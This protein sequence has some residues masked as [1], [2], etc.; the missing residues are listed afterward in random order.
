MRIQKKNLVTINLDESIDSK[1]FSVD[2]IINKDAFLKAIKLI[3]DNVRFLNSRQSVQIE[4][5]ARNSNTISILGGRG[6]GKSS[7]IY[8]LKNDCEEN[9]K[10]DVLCLDIIDPTLVEAKG[11]FL[12]YVLSLLDAYVEKFINSPSSYSNDQI[13]KLERHSWREA[14][15][16]LAKGLCSVDG[17]D[18]QQIAEWGDDNY[19]FRMGM[20][21]VSSSREIQNNLYRLVNKAL[22][23]K[24]QTLLVL[25]FDDIDVDLS[26]SW[27]VLE[28][29]RK[30][31][32]LP[33]ILTIISGDEYLL[34]LSVRKAQWQKFD[35]DFLVSE[36]IEK[37]E[38]VEIRQSLEDQYLQ[39]ILKLENRISL[40][41]L[42]ELTSRLSYTLNFTMNNCEKN[43]ELISIYKDFF[44]ILGIFQEVDMEDCFNVLLSLP[45]RSQIHLIR[46]LLS[47][48]D[49]KASSMAELE[50]KVRNTFY[51][52][53]LHNGV[54]IDEI[55]KNQ[56]FI[57]SHILKYLTHSSN[58]RLFNC[59][60]LQPIALSGSQNEILFSLGSIFSLFCRRRPT[61][62]LDY[63]LRIAFTRN[64]IQKSQ[65]PLS[66]FMYEDRNMRDLIGYLIAERKPGMIAINFENLNQPIHQS[67][68]LDSK[69]NIVLE[70]EIFRIF[71]Y[72]PVCLVRKSGNRRIEKY[73]S[74][75]FLLGTIYDFMRTDNVVQ[76]IQKTIQL[77]IYSDL[78][79]SSDTRE[80][81]SYLAE[82]DLTITLNEDSY[83]EEIVKKFAQIFND[84][85]EQVIKSAQGSAINP[86]LLGRIMTRYYSATE[87]IKARLNSFKVFPLHIS[88]FLNSILIEEYLWGNK[89]DKYIRFNYNNPQND[90]M[91]FIN[92]LAHLKLFNISQDFPI[93]NFFITC[94]LIQIYINP[95]IL[96]MVQAGLSSLIR[97]INLYTIYEYGERKITSESAKIEKSSKSSKSS[98]SE[99]DLT[100]QLIKF[101]KMEKGLSFE[102][103]IGMPIKQLVDEFPSLKH[104]D[105]TIEKIRLIREELK[106]GSLEW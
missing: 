32:A 94:P 55:F 56:D 100:D 33:N 91:I 34:S 57:V 89:Q 40:M 71:R 105:N 63:M 15:N 35:N 65:I 86:L 73:Y 88:I 2:K 43:G 44:R 97:Q 77:K 31:L 41:S 47:V 79:E 58:E 74:F 7:F 87:N 99:I 85:K 52:T 96:E 14:L 78:I 68:L 20:S 69:E 6:S 54:S 92:N 72:L 45:L 26:K 16:K 102:E 60:Q 81:N 104:D 38:Y 4:S 28:V 93:L 50:D 48:T 17:I 12:L 82:H 10:T 22:A 62:I 25:F 101:F 70:S 46:A 106:K 59:Y 24:N 18:S 53:L 83:S 23:Y 27:Q 9:H 42:K 1:S 29:I 36:R 67:L 21:S 37:R 19:I 30:Y 51:T 84:W 80:N 8:S 103:F 39:K 98:I 49:N 64:V 75:P 90:E 11:H 3:D 66:Q 5:T 61:L 95:E 76:Q 13:R